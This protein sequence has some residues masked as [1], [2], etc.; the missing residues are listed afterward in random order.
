MAGVDA[1]I[2]FRIANAVLAAASLSIAALIVV[3]ISRRSSR[4]L[5]PLGLAF[6]AVFLAVGLRATVRTAVGGLAPGNENATLYLVVDWL[7]ALAAVAFLALR[8]RYG[9]FIESATIV[10]EYEHEFAEKERE[11]RSLAQI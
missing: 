7:G 11:A 2:L 6:L 1:D 5:E 9:I 8:R 4:N 3:A 10:R